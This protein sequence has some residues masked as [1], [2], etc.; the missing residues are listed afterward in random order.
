MNGEKIEK[1]LREVCFKIRVKGREALREYAITPAKF[2]VLQRLYFGGPQT[3]STLSQSLGI[4]KSTT[5]G[6]IKRLEKEGFV[7]REVN[8][9]D[10]RVV[11]VRITQKGVNVINSVIR[12]RIE[13][14]S[15]VMK[16][17]SFEENSKFEELL[18]KFDEKV[19]EL[20]DKNG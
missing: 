4:A 12:R 13:F 3:M 19:L 8:N 14:V 20:T 5:T 16:V 17:F 6:L 18:V 1:I 2:D 15:E 9:D 10:K 7:E 11:F